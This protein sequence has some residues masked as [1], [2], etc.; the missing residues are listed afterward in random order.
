MQRRIRNRVY[1]AQAGAKAEF[2]IH[3]CTPSGEELDIPS[4][5]HLRIGPVLGDRISKLAGRTG[6]YLAE[7]DAPT[8]VCGLLAWFGPCC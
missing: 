4:I 8:K 6:V 3:T 5:K 2:L 1:S 7:Y